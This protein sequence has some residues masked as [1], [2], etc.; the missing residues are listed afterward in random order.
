MQQ[1]GVSV[2]ACRTADRA[3]WDDAALLQEYIA[4][5]D[6]SA[7]AQIASRHG[8]MVYRTCLRQLRQAQDAEDATQAVFLILARQ[9]RRAQGALAGWLHKTAH[10][11]AISLL[12]QRQRRTR[13]E[14]AAAVNRS[15]SQSVDR[16]PL[17]QEVDRGI[18]RLPRPLREAVVLCYLEG[19]RQEEAAQILGC[20]QGTLSR[21]AAAGIEQLRALL[22]GCGVPITTPALVAYLLQ[23]QAQA[24]PSAAFL[25]SLK[26]AAAAPG[27]VAGAF[28]AQATSIANGMI[29][30]AVMAKMKIAAGIVLLTATLGVGGG[31][32]LWQRQSPP[33]SCVL[34]DFD[35][36]TLAKNQA[37][38]AYPSPAAGPGG[39]GNFT[40]SLEPRDAIAGQ[41]LHLQLTD[42]ILKCQF[43]PDL[44]KR[45]GFTR[46]QVAR[47]ADWRMNTY[48]RFRFWIKRPTSVQPHFTDGKANV[49]VGAYVKRVQDADAGSLD[50][51]GGAFYHYLNVPATGHWTQ[52]V[53]NMHPSQLLGRHEQGEL[54]N[55]PHPTGEPAV[56]Y[57]DALTRFFIEDRSPPAAYP[58]DYYLDNLEFFTA[59]ESENDDQVYSVTGTYV[60]A[61]RRLIVTWNRNKAEDS[62]A[63]EVRF[64][65]RD[66]HRIG[67]S[68]ATPAPGG[69]VAP[70]GKG[71]N[72]GMVYDSSALPL[73]GQECVYIAIRP[74]NSERFT[75][76]AIPLK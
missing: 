75:Q 67:W 4:S 13:R 63:H 2:N 39:G 47:P 12:R 57:F 69:T 9:P 64:A 28:S 18:A 52:V 49:M 16:E 68:S 36:G 26:L 7:F 27:V 32:Y 62:I 30:S 51:G 35:G 60:L 5:H 53:L 46:E 37:G 58:A 48:N 71:A 31:A 72:Q 8:A 44:P 33:P 19:R 17:Q 40:M 20:N 23:A 59:P 55:R 73:E 11:T 6:E 38:E 42:G 50:A 1:P 45:K 54:G 74:A 66:I 29:Q 25:A 10:D 3:T 43:D 56:N 76:I 70:P 34:L 65:F 15:Q 14:E 22:L 41:S 24:V 61:S 21:R